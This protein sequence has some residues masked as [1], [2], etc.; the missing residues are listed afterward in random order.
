MAIS[1][2]QIASVTKYEHE[3]YEKITLRMYKGERDTIKSAADLHGMSVNAYIIGLIR[4]G[5]ERDGLKLPDRPGDAAEEKTE[6]E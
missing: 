4:E 3:H 6:E 5:L 2:K 1:K